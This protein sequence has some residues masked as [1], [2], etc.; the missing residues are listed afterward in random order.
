LFE[1]S[2]YIFSDMLE[3][4]PTTVMPLD[5]LLQI[6]MNFIFSYPFYFVIDFV[7]RLTLAQEDWRDSSVKNHDQEPI[8]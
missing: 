8:V 1:L 3:A 2:Y 6:L 4:T 5:R 7:D